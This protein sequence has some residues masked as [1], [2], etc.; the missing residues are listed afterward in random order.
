MWSADDPDLGAVREAAARGLP[1]AVAGEVWQ[2][3]L[4]PQ[5]VADMGR[6]DAAVRAARCFC[7]SLDFDWA[8]TVRYTPLPCYTPLRCYTPLP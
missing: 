3:L 8:G 4:G 6:Y 1:A 5:V 7:D 2:A